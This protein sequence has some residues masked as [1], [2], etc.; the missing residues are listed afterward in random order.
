MQRTPRRSELGIGD[1]IRALAELGID[2]TEQIECV[3]RC[4]GLDYGSQ[5][6]LTDIAQ[7]RQRS[8][9]NP[10][11]ASD[12]RSAP[13]PLPALKPGGSVKLPVPP[14][15]E[16]SGEPLRIHLK[17]QDP[18]IPHLPKPDTD[19][20]ET[21]R[22]PLKSSSD[23]ATR[24]PLLP[25]LTARGVLGEVIATW[26]ASEQPHI[27]AIIDHIVRG[28]ALIELP[29]L[30]KKTVNLGCQLLL[31]FNEALLPWHEDMRELRRSLEG[32]LGKEQLEVYRFDESP[33]EATGL[34][35]ENR[36]ENWKPRHQV[37]V[38]VAT[39]LGV[40]QAPDSPLR[41]GISTW[42]RLKRY[43]NLHQV[44]LTAFVPLHPERERRRQL[45]G[46]INIIHWSPDTSA[47]NVRIKDR[48][49]DR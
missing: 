8:G 6:R 25:K 24:V 40:F 17:Q 34:Q 47:M 7:P 2:D 3:A 15:P 27:T 18:E 43:C 48:P 49:R 45:E 22:R 5:S 41:P 36:G 1:F 16:P 42:I 9:Y 31:D 19:S 20:V 28:K 44:P 33:F 29:R 37:P 12:K 14:P 21:L 46:S 26:V 4:M 32:L 23:A 11:R 10:H 35:K 30:P 38:I 13:Q 39:D